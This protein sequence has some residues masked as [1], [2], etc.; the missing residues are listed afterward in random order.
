MKQFIKEHA[1]VLKLVFY[2]LI[3]VAVVFI[4]KGQIAEL[5]GERMHAV[6]SG[7]PKPLLMELVILAFV[8]FSAT[9]LYDVFAAR[10]VGVDLPAAHALRIGWI[11][12]AFNNFAGLGGLTGGTIRAR[13]YSKAGADPKKAVGV[14]VAVW[15]ANLLGLFALL[16]VTLPF[17]SR[18]DG[19]FLIVPV[20]ACLYIPIY[21]IAGKIHFWKIDLRSTVLGQ[22]DW[23]TKVGMFIA[24]L[25][26][27]LAAALFFWLCVHVFSPGVGLLQAIFVYA[28]ATLVGL[29]SFVPAGLGTFD[30]TVFAFFS[31]MGADPSE[32]ALALV[33]YR[34][35]YYLFPWLA[36][37]GAWLYEFIAP[38]IGLVNRERREAVLVT[39]LWVAM[40]FTGV[41]L[42][43]SAVAP[44]FTRLPGFLHYLVPIEVA[45]ASRAACLMVG[46]MLVILSRGIRQKIQRVHTA[47]LVLLIVAIVAGT[48][49]GFDTQMIVVLVIFA[50]LLYLS[51]GAFVRGP[52]DFE[53]KSFTVSLVIAIGVPLAIFA[54]RWSKIPD[55][56]QV[57]PHAGWRTGIFYLL[58][59]T[60]VALGL[61]FSRSRAPGF[62]YPTPEETRRFEDFVAKYGATPYTHLFYLGDKSVFYNEAGT[63]AL[64]YRPWRNLL[65]ALGDPIGDEDAFEELLDEFVS[66]ADTHG[67]KASIYEISAKYLA[68]AANTGYSFLKIGEDATVVLEDYSNVG[69]KGKVFR[70]MRNRMG[71]KGTHFEMVHP[72]FSPE[73][74]SE[75][76]DVSDSWLRGRDEMGFSLG[77]FDP[78]YLGRAPVAVVRSEARVEG[79]A[80]LMPMEEGV[81]SVDLMRIRPDAPGGTMDGLFVSLIEWAK[82]AGYHAFNLGMAPLSNTGSSRH[83]RAQEKIVRYVYDFGNR[84]YNFRGLRSYKEKFKP[85]W[86][87]RYLIYSGASS[88][89]P[90]LLAL[91]SAVQHPDRTHGAIPLTDS[92]PESAIAID[93]PAALAAQQETHPENA[94]S[95]Q[96]QNS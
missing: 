95:A 36:A 51:R 63:A 4:A 11:A 73:F 69:N 81:A 22:Q 79:F 3:A 54:W 34:V 74:L 82:E 33:A 86:I 48:A 6:L 37:V 59:V 77:F 92:H 29:L 26:D 90:T 41:A 85:K 75:I 78:D 24:S 23:R 91:L 46:L 94:P 20:I 64:M 32:L 93:C 96:A 35:T 30:V 56:V 14:S 17:A 55:G 31:Q 84:V 67:C 43:V 72:P 60:I 88:L 39:V 57:Y 65:L 83:S 61:L 80:N 19:R 66:F 10:S 47:C 68:A 71:E 9:G 18:Y 53:W 38:K 25:A 76:R 7:T 27:W 28:T 58:L 2:A 89:V 1:K 62:E 8:A 13:Y 50:A 21:F 45:R 16:L 15:A 49:R 52:L 42:I 40:F 44:G 87:S 5:S 12:Q 70:R